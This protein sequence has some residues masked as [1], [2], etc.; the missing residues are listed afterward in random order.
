M[1]RRATVGGAPE[2]VHAHDVVSAAVRET[3]VPQPCDAGDGA[4]G[5]RAKEVGTPGGGL[6][7]DG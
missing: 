1:Q 2:G 3:G 4:D 7:G 5:G 6:G